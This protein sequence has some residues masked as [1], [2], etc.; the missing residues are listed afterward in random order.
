MPASAIVQVDGP[1]VVI[2][3]LGGGKF[4]TVLL[5]EMN[6]CRFAMKQTKTMVDYGRNVHE[7]K[8]LL[9]EAQKCMLRYTPSRV[10]KLA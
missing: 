2:S 9:Q 3:K 6:G 8:K 7:R 10:S 1:F 5:V 4:A